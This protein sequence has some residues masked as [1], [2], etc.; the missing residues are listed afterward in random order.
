MKTHSTCNKRDVLNKFTTN[1]KF[2]QRKS[3]LAENLKIRKSFPFLDLFLLLYLYLYWNE[4]WKHIQR[5]IE[6]FAEENQSWILYKLINIKSFRTCCIYIDI[7]KKTHLGCDK[8]DALIIFRLVCIIGE[9]VH[10]SRL[11]VL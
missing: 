9:H 2:R 3:K 4:K 5:R 1:R 7:I 10:F 6:N 11:T 8:C